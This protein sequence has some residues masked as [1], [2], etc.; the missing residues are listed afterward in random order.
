MHVS[1][2]T[3]FIAGTQSAKV[4]V[5]DL[6]GRPVFRGKCEKGSVELSGFSEGLYVVRV[7]SGSASL[8]KRIAIK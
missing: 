5:F 8:T 7:R 4:D 1:G 2:H 3:L 6:Q